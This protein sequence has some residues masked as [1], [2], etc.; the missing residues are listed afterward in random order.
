MLNFQASMEYSKNMQ[1][2][3]DDSVMLIDYI[4]FI[5]I[6]RTNMIYTFLKDLLY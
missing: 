2:Q 6:N 4:V 5:E 3:L 1:Y